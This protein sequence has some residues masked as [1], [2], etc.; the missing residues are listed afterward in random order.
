MFTLGLIL[1]TGRIV[2]AQ[3]TATPSAIPSSIP[4]PDPIRNKIK[5]DL[6]SNK[7]RLPRAYLGTVTDISENTIEI[8]NNSGEIQLLTVD[9]EESDFVRIT[10]ISKN[11]TFKDIAIADYI[12]AMGFVSDNNILEATRILATEPVKPT[13]RTAILGTVQTVT[14][15]DL[16]ITTSNGST[17]IITPTKNVSIQNNQE[18]KIKLADIETGNS[19]IAIG[20]Q[21]GNS[22]SARTIQLR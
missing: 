14:T 1:T 20:D 6:D 3:Q 19:I 9:P 2:H 17:M 12:I 8:K 11:I 22:I 10:T 5:Q 15:K 4:T 18:T 16:T 21:S 13:S 7:I